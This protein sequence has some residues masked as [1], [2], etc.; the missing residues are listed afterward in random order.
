MLRFK[1]KEN[2]RELQSS[3]LDRFQLVWE[4]VDNLGSKPRIPVR[5]ASPDPLAKESMMKQL[6]IGVDV[7]L[8]Q[9]DVATWTEQKAE[10]R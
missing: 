5:C 1:P 4:N 3:Y 8:K 9:L 7:S 6:I 2:G 10:F